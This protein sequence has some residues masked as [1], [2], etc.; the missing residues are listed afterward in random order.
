MTQDTTR[1]DESD[2]RLGNVSKIVRALYG[3][4]AHWL[5]IVVVEDDD[6]PGFRVVDGLTVY[7][8][9]GERAVPP[10][11]GASQCD[12][13]DLNSR[14]LS[15]FNIRDAAAYRRAMSDRDATARILDAIDQAVVS[16]LDET[17]VG[18]VLGL[19]IDKHEEFGVG[20][21]ELI[22]R[23][24]GTQ[25][26]LTL[27][28]TVDGRALDLAQTGRRLT[29]SAAASAG[30]FDVFEPGEDFDGMI[31]STSEPLTL[32]RP[33][34]NPSPGRPEDDAAQ[35]GQYLVRQAVYV[36][37]R[38]THAGLIRTAHP[39]VATE[40]F[41]AQVLT[42][43]PVLAGEIDE[44]FRPLYFSS[45]EELAALNLNDLDYAHLTASAE[46]HH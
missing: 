34:E 38:V 25:I 17:D 2:L 36:I 1:H 42:G 15:T 16:C 43:R 14:L 18:D 10:Y 41:N 45:P 6:N 8:A 7:D 40:T 9:H 39:A 19:L 44:S 23:P 20:S 21:H 28:T 46:Q 4:A 35:E 22:L 3:P 31:I 30:A 33:Q 32:P 37:T 12:T 13:P 27:R 5:L 29:P 24:T 26:D 11:E